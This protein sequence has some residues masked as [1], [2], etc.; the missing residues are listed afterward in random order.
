MSD[1]FPDH[2][3][4]LLSRFREGQLSQKESQTLSDYADKDPSLLDHA[5]LVQGLRADA[6]V[7]AEWERRGLL[8]A[9][10]ATA[11]RG[12]IPVITQLRRTQRRP[13]WLATAA[14]IMLACGLGYWTAQSLGTEPQHVLQVTHRQE[15]TLGDGIVAIV[16]PGTQI[17]ESNQGWFIR[18]GRAMVSADEGDWSSFELGTPHG[19]LKIIGTAYEVEVQADHSDLKVFEGSVAAGSAQTNVDEGEALRLGLEPDAVA[20]PMTASIPSAVTSLQRTP[21]YLF[22]RL[23][24]RGSPRQRHLDIPPVPSERFTV[25]WPIMLEA[26]GEIGYTV[27]YGS[28]D[29]S[30][31]PKE[32]ELKKPGKSRLMAGK[33]LT[34]ELHYV[35]LG[36]QSGFDGWLVEIRVDGHPLLRDLINNQPPQVQF[37]LTSGT[38][39]GGE[40]TLHLDP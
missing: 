28:T 4:I 29:G 37:S 31:I 21:S 7:D 24:T 22:K 19:P 38:V 11:S 36:Q 5:L 16:D 15:L 17:I 26:P 32:L 39:R 12:A 8:A 3:E 27:T 40:A 18:R 20:K 30:N 23:E 2:I 35:F 14:A 33:W 34:C 1:S 6:M 25:T 10:G 9:L 13:L